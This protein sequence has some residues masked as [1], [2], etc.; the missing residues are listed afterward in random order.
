[1]PKC[2]SCPNG[3]WKAHYGYK[4]CRTSACG[5]ESYKSCEHSQCG[6]KQYKKC[7]T[8][9]CGVEEYKT[10]YHYRPCDNYS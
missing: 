8:S 3:T 10:C 4:T 6:I 9:A 7:R 1:M 5:V 2:G